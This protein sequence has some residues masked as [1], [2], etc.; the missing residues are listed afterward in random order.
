MTALWIAST[1]FFLAT[2]AVGFYLW[3][4]KK[5]EVGH[6]TSELHTQ[7]MLTEEKERAFLVNRQDLENNF[8]ILATRALHQQSEEFLKLASER[9]DRKTVEAKSI[10][11][12]KTLAIQKLVEPIEKTLSEVQTNLSDFERRRVEQFGQITEQIRNV[13]KSSEILQKET[14]VLSS[15]LKKPEVRG[16]W[17]EI[18][19][20]RLMEIA[21]MSVH[22]DF[23]EQV[24]VQSEKGQLRPDVTVNLPNKRIL[25]IDAKV[26]LTSFVEYLESDKDEVKL[27]ARERHSFHVKSKIKELS[28]KSYWDQ[29]QESPEFVILFIP[30]EA[31]LQIALE[32]DRGLLEMAWESKVIIAT[33]TTLIALMK[34]VAYGW[35]QQEVAENAQK[36]FE[37]TQDLFERLSIWQDHLKKVGVKLSESVASYN[38]SVGSLENRVLPSIRKIQQIGATQKEVT[39]LPLIETQVRELK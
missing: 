17:G 26:V 19:L 3:Q 4:R 16:S 6:L 18:Q 34:A 25:V 12:E 27:K 37:S 8:Q 35:Q 29:F 20:K 23:S 36:I 2:T 1:L 15:A 9:L 28:M 31:A 22:C 7:K 38:Q 24:T 10:F 13:V 33:P 11:D 5:E 21:G 14:Q 39:E 30:N 32:D